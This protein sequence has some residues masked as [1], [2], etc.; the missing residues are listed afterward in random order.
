MIEHIIANNNS[1][2]IIPLT[3]GQVGAELAYDVTKS[4]SSAYV[5]H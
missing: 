2:A 5:N 4:P 3:R 1:S